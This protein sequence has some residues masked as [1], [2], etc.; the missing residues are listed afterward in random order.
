MICVVLGIIV[1]NCL[2]NA[3]AIVHRFSSIKKENR[4]IRK[5]LPIIYSLP[6]TQRGEERGEKEKKTRR[7]EESIAR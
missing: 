6:M 3:R 2:M 7:R 5:K 1:Q 4:S